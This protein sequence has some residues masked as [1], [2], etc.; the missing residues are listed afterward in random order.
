MNEYD[1]K[2]AAPEKPSAF[3][4]MLNKIESIENQTM[5]ATQILNEITERLEGPKPSTVEGAKDQSGH[6]SLLGQIA[7]RLSDADGAAGNVLHAA[8]HLNGVIR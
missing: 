7:Q 6:S 8:Q 5:Q 4:D 2:L 1:T 3:D